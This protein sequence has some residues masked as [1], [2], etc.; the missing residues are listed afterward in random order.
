[1]PI[2]R[3][4]GNDK[5]PDQVHQRVTTT[6]RCMVNKRRNSINILL[7]LAGSFAGGVVGNY[8]WSGQSVAMAAAARAARVVKAQKFVLVGPK[9]EER[10]V[11]DVAST[12]TAFIAL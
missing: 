11:L 4:L 9:G 10:A 8:L 7:I 5:Y 6:R 12:G 2:R 3:V 1:G